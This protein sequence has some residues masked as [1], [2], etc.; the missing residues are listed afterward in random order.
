MEAARLVKP[1][2]KCAERSGARVEDLGRSLGVSADHD[3]S[4]VGKERR[5]VAES[6]G[7]ERGA[8]GENVAGGVVEL[9]CSE[10]FTSAATGQSDPVARMTA[11]RM[12][13]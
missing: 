7:V 9:G 2:G 10:R 13:A 12:A 6:G 1:A 11:A 8:G 4:S 3:D 5:G